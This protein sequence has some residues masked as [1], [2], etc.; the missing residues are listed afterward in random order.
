MNSFS[1]PPPPGA[2]TSSQ[3][4]AGLPRMQ[5]LSTCTSS[6]CVME[7]ALTHYPLSYP[8]ACWSCHRGC[9]SCSPSPHHP[10]TKA[11]TSRQSFPPCAPQ[12]CKET[13]QTQHATRLLC[14]WALRASGLAR[15]KLRQGTYE[16]TTSKSSDRN[17]IHKKNL[18]AGGAVKPYSADIP[19]LADGHL[20]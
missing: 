3:P 17:K 16:L 8:Q 14:H 11:L 13:R 19:T 7:G 2:S 20:L 12:T 5:E 9:P 15:G 6:S 1:L 4:S 18:G 10:A